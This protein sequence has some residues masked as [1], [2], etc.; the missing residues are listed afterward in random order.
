MDYAFMYVLQE[1]REKGD[2]LFYLDMPDNLAIDAWACEDLC[3]SC[4][5]ISCPQGQDPRWVNGYDDKGNSIIVSCP[6]FIDKRELEG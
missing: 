1:I 5:G 2:S 3:N 4:A 6:S